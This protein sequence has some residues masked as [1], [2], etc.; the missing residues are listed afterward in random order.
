M[1][2]ARPLIVVSA[3]SLGLALGAMMSHVPVRAQGEAHVHVFIVPLAV[4]D[5]KTPVPADLPGE[6]IAGISCLTKPQE[7][8]PNAAVCY[9]ATSLQ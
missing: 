2:L 6:R 7:K 5:A 4:P 8:L 1:K 3:T 9:V